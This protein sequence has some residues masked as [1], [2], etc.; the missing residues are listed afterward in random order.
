MEYCCPPVYSQKDKDLSM[1]SILMFNQMEMKMCKKK[2]QKMM[3]LQQAKTSFGSYLGGEGVASFSATGTSV[4]S[5]LQ[6]VGDSFPIPVSFMEIEIKQTELSKDLEMLNQM[7]SIGI[8]VSLEIIDNILLKARVLQQIVAGKKTL[9]EASASATSGNARE[10]TMEPIQLFTKNMEDEGIDMVP[11]RGILEDYQRGGISDGGLRDQLS[12]ALGQN[13]FLLSE[14]DKLQSKITSARALERANYEAGE[15]F[16]LAQNE[17]AVKR[18]EQS[19]AFILLQK[20][21]QLRQQTEEISKTS[22]I[23]EFAA[24]PQSHKKK[25][26]YAAAKAV[27]DYIT[28]GSKQEA[29]QIESRFKSEFGVDW[30][31]INKIQKS[32]ELIE[33]LYEEVQLVNPDTNWKGFYES[34]RPNLRDESVDNQTLIENFKSFTQDP[35]ASYDPDNQVLIADMDQEIADYDFPDRRDLRPMFEP[36]AEPGPSASAPPRVDEMRP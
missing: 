1:V 20:E 13:K 8:P 9:L 16:G 2:K 15:Y 19:A 34:V 6:P 31:A 27:S 28:L 12:A 17:E 33:M 25:F 4:S 21:A 36:A 5:R 22:L 29:A 10:L 24:I 14:L 35:E 30:R 23:N 18:M 7:N 3:G 11:V 32:K 26:F